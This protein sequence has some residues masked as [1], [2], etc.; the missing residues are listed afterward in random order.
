M[1]FADNLDAFTEAL[2]V[3]NAPTIVYLS[4]VPWPDPNTRNDFIFALTNRDMRYADPV[5][6]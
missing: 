1:S 3:E 2:G 5:E 4:M 6:G